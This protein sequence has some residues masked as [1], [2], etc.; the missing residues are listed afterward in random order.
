M[1]RVFVVQCEN[2][3]VATSNAIGV[4]LNKVGGLDSIVKN[5]DLVLLK[6][7]FVAP[8]PDATTNLNLLSEVI[9]RVR[10]CG[11]EAII[12]ESSGFEFNTGKTFELLG[13][14]QFSKEKDIKI[15]NF[16]EGE[17]CTEKADNL[18]LKIPKIF[19]ECDK[20]INIPKLKMHSVTTV[21]LALKNLVGAVHRDTRR[22]IHVTN[23]S[24]GI[25]S[26]N[27]I[28]RPDITIV[29]GLGFLSKRAVFGEKRD[30]NYLIAGRTSI[31]VDIA[32]CGMLG[33]DP[34]KIR[35][36]SIAKKELGY[37]KEIQIEG[38]YFPGCLATPGGDS[39]LG[40][41]LHNML[42]WGLYVSDLL[43]SKGTSKSLIPYFHW[44]FGVRPVIDK[45]RC[46]LCGECVKS[47]PVNAIT[48]GNDVKIDRHFCQDVRCL[49]C[50][51][52][53]PNRAISAT[54]GCS[55]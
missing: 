45:R 7:N 18:T 15:I 37:I 47:C 46:T 16:D 31:A 20:L 11:G 5:G 28:L 52:I 1:E 19:F 24:K 49:K 27:K 38:D 55:L 25:I 36:I 17:F 29:D 33:I 13:L 6:P 9:D 3:N 39:T 44:H 2:N 48:L 4:I 30:A 32:C 40:Q 51:H 14:H 26:I 50:M 10:M 42:F 23:L 21:S 35:H 12:G 41:R 43:Y 53:C 22:M 34:E 8:F 54:K